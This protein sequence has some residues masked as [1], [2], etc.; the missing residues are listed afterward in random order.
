MVL[1]HYRALVVKAEQSVAAE[2][3]E[4]VAMLASSLH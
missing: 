1:R 3:Q 2:L 4:L